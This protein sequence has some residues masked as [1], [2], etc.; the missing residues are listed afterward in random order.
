MIAQNGTRDDKFGDVSKNTGYSR[1][2]K[3]GKL[4]KGVELR[5]E[6][7][8]DMELQQNQPALISFSAGPKCRPGTS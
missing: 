2:F 4:E 7:R 8:S 1:Y 3:I 6:L 5:S